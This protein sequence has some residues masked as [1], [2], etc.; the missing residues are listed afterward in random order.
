MGMIRFSTAITL[1]ITSSLVTISEATLINM[2]SY[3]VEG[4]IGNDQ[5]TI[6]EGI[7]STALTGFYDT[8][9][10]T[11]WYGLQ[12]HSNNTFT[13]SAYNYDGRTPLPFDE[14]N[15]GNAVPLLQIGNLSLV[16]INGSSYAEFVLDI[17]EEKDML[18]LDTFKLFVY[19]DP[20]TSPYITSTSQLNELGTLVYDL[21]ASADYSILI[22]DRGP[23]RSSEDLSVF[24]SADA[25]NS[26]ADSSKVYLYTEFGNVGLVNETLN[27]VPTG[28][29]LNFEVDASPDRWQVRRVGNDFVQPVPEASTI[30]GASVI[31]L[32]MVLIALKRRKSQAL[33]A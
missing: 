21:D 14:K 22:Q 19:D 5:I 16:D 18:S 25:F 29:G 20:F 9:N 2:T 24:V 13:Q 23:S 11:Q 10:L 31:S 27:G 15:L 17:T 28:T 32:C 30:I 7:F 1:F 4:I 3:E 12:N 33:P 26:H 6:N 8:G